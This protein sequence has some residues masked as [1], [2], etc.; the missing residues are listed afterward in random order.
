MQRLL[1]EERHKEKK[2]ERKN[3]EKVRVW[4]RLVGINTK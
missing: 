2:E 1:E 4:S 3:E